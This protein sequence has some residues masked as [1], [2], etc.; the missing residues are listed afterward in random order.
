MARTYPGLALGKLKKLASLEQFS[1]FSPASPGYVR[2]ALRKVREA[3]RAGCFNGK[4]QKHSIAWHLI[5]I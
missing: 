4:G 1:T 2:L 5:L 3:R